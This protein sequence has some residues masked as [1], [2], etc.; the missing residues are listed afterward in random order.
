MRLACGWHVAFF[1][2][3]ELA[4]NGLLISKDKL[5]M[6]KQQETVQKFFGSISVINR[7]K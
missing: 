4:S 2:D 6:L 5:L 7:L 1:A 3:V